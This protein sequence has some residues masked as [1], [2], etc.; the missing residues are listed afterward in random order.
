M[1]LH[2]KA[3]DRRKRNLEKSIKH[4]YGHAEIGKMVEKSVGKYGA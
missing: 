3:I 1:L 4:I 2:Y